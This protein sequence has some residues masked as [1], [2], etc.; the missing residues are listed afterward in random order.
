MLKV[1]QWCN[2]DFDDRANARYCS[3][4]HFKDCENPGCDNSFK[5]AE[6]KRPAKC[7][8]KPCSDVLTKLNNQGTEKNCDFCGES[9]IAK[10]SSELYCSREH[11]STCIVCKNEFKAVRLDR[12]ATT[13][14]KACA[15]RITDFD[16]R[17]KK[18]E[19]TLMAAYGVR[20][21]SQIEEVKEKKIAASLFKY[22]VPNVSQAKEVQEKRESTFMDRYGEN[23]PMRVESIKKKLQETILQKYGHVNQFMN[24]DVKQKSR[25]TMLDR[26]GV[27][28]IFQLPEVQ[29]KA[30]ENSG[31]RIS[32]VNI[33]WH[34]LLLK[35][36]ELDFEYETRF[37]KFYADLSY[38]NLLIDINPTFTHNSTISFAHAT[39]RCTEENCSKVSHMPKPETYHQERALEASK[40]GF[41]LL[42]YFDWFDEKIFLNI[43]KSQL[44]AL[45]VRIAAK[46]T[47]LREI[48]QSEANSFLRE[49][50]LLGASNKQSLCLGLFAKDTN[51]L[52]HVQTYGESRLNNNIAWEA[53]RSCSKND[54]QIIGGFSKCDSYFFKKIQPDSVVS[55]VDLSVSAGHTDSMFDGWFLKSIN[56]PSG[57]WVRVTDN[58]SQPLFVKD[59]TARRIGADRLLGFEI[60]DKYPR[61]HEDGSKV[62]NDFV[63][64]SEGYIKMNDAGTAVYLWQKDKLV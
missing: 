26:Y 16:A 9:F 27:E 13:C 45:P 8:S 30:A 35:E 29:K 62:T 12:L 64:L 58:D 33:R 1:C 52:V 28:N 61:L 37:G 11:F 20:N 49:N 40:H 10:K 7:C 57:V 38:G 54:Y 21:A 51:E 32:K 6:M 44:K 23:N 18:S 56:K 17:N 50:H 41:L 46:N 42:Q 36:T 3:D 22:G 4:D 55:Y 14:S 53:I 2:K 59:N 24:K 19:E 5:I 47:V 63:L 39:G 34:D 15:S 43:V 48:K 60:G 31:L 25:S